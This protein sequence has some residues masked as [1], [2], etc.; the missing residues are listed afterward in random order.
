MD[1]DI[2]KVLEAFD[3][4]VFYEEEA[5]EGFERPVGSKP[6]MIKHLNA[7]HLGDVSGK[8]IPDIKDLLIKALE[9]EKAKREQ[10]AREMISVANNE[11]QDSR[12][13]EYASMEDQD[14]LIEELISIVRKYGV[15]V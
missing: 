9:A 1:K 5:A 8:L 14:I 11:K 7:E 13:I 2:E 12:Y 15:E 10:M 4:L 3:K 6:Y